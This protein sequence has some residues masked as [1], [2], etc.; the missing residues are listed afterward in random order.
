MTPF[1]SAMDIVLIV[2]YGI[3]SAIFIPLFVVILVKLSKDY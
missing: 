2:V 1:D 3:T